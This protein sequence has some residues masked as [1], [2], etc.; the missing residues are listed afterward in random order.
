MKVFVSTTKEA[1]GMGGALLA[2]YAWRK[3]EN[4]SRASVD[5]IDSEVSV[6][7]ECVAEPIPENTQVYDSLI[8]IYEACES[9]V[10][11]M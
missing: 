8:P 4:D 7:M 10:L 9:Q 11:C 6:G 1:A 5:M 3:V 2:R